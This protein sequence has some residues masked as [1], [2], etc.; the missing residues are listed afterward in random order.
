MFGRRASFWIAVGGAAV[1]TPFA[2]RLAAMKVPVP[3]LQRFINFTYG[4]NGAN[5]A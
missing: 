2:L 1:L 4:Q 3:G 5:R